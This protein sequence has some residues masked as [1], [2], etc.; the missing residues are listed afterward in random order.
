MRTST[1]SS[2]LV[3]AVL[4]LTGCAA[5][6]S[7][8]MASSD[9]EG[10]PTG[11]ENNAAGT[12]SQ[13][14]SDH[15]GQGTGGSTTG[16]PGQG[17]GGS[18][19]GYPG[20]AAGSAGHGTG[21][22]SGGA[23]GA[24]TSAGGGPPA[25]GGSAGGATG[26]AGSAGGATGPA[27]SGGSAAGSGG[28]AAGSG[29][30]AGSGEA[31]SAGSSGSSEA[32]Q[33]GAGGSAAE[34][35][36]GVDKSQP[37]TIYLS[38]D[39]SNS[40][41]SPAIV[42]KL[43]RNGQSPYP[44]LVRT[45]EFLN[46]YNVAY[47]P[48]APNDLALVPQMRP[49]KKNG[50]YELQIG[51]QSA[52]AGVRRPVTL[53]LVLDTSG[54][55]QGDPIALLKESVHAMAAQLQAGDIVSITTWNTAVNVALGG[56]QA[57]GP[58]D[59]A[60]LDA[61]DALEAG[62][63][64]DLEQGLANGYQLARQYY[65]EGRINRVVLVSD[66]VANVGITDE[67]MIGKEA[68]VQ[69]KE[70]IYLVGV[71]VGEG[72]NDTLLN[73]VSD[74]GNGAYLY[75]DSKEE[76]WKMLGTRFDESM[77]IAA[78]N[79]RTAMTLPW[80]LAITKFDGEQFSTDPTKVK[81]QHLAPGDAMVYHQILQACDPGVVQASDPVSFQAT[82]TEPTTFKPR[83]TQVDTTVGALLEGQDA[84]LR[85]GRAIVA[86]ADALKLGQSCSTRHALVAEAK[87]DADLSDPA[88]QDES[89]NE[90]RELLTLWDKGCP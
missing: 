88:A 34:L 46:Y 62:G 69:D 68:D 51:A 49:A 1:F 9:L 20:Q 47:D 82:W 84:Q 56:Y 58:S 43:L 79:V 5:D 52:P 12:S 23:G 54:S 45:Y 30:S 78:R 60:I 39:D 85:R 48:P 65:A 7:T 25:S 8:D 19:T 27:G 77:E 61:V 81:P 72:V 6:S 64:T 26:P 67:Q 24:Q 41:A 80:Y 28:S 37:T 71:G 44:S 14:P 73:V 63:G 36:P 32:G 50:S 83:T 86:Y 22:G 21:L 74:A 18:T 66:G 38:A 87:A 57:T 2:V 55:M 31:G 70:S 13:N 10:M 75:L 29:G 3:A 89:M 53:T 35:C 90:I 17:A 4:S 76:A 15:S 16:Y 42:R 40:M 59:P 33:G 11:Y